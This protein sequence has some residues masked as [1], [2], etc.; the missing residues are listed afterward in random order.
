MEYNN[1]ALADIA[2]ISVIKNEEDIIYYNLIWHYNIGIRKFII[3][4]NMSTDSTYQMVKI[5]RDRFT[6]VS[7]YLI[8]DQNPAFIQGTKM[9]SMANFAMSMWDIKWI[10]PIDADE[11]LCPSK[12]LNELLS[13][14]PKNHSLLISKLF[15][16]LCDDSNGVFYK[17]IEKR[18]K[19][20]QWSKKVIIRAAEGLLI[21]QGNHTSFVNN[22]EVPTVE[23]TNIIYREF[24]IRNKTQ[25]FNKIINGAIATKKALELKYE[26]GSN[27]WLAPYNE[28]LKGGK[29]SLSKIF[30]IYI[31]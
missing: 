8:D 25:Y 30:E 27:H 17:R 3:M 4:D 15:Y 22:V 19:I 7:L 23:S 29:E 26:A 10:I 9:T 14:V 2:M 5:F 24:M 18:E 6:D 11:F 28:Y 20:S 21:S 13:E 16:R 1:K 31:N 12:P